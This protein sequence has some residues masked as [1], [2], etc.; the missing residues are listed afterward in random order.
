MDLTYDP[1]GKR[2]NFYCTYEQRDIPKRAGFRHFDKQRRCWWTEHPH[3]A[4]RLFS[5]AKQERTRLH[6]RS[7]A[8]TMSAQKIA[9]NLV[10]LPA[11]IELPTIPVPANRAYRSFQVAGIHYML[12]HPR[13][14]NADDPGLGKTIEAIGVI[15]AD[16][17]LHR[18]LIVCLAGMKIN[19]ARELQRWLTRDY[20]ISIA[21]SKKWRAQIVTPGD[22]GQITIINY[23]ALSK[24]PDKLTGIAWDCFIADE[25]HMLK[26]A[27]TK[28]SQHAY[29]ITASKRTIFLTGTPAPNYPRELF[30]LVH[31]LDPEGFPDF[32][33]YAQEFCG[34]EVRE[35]GSKERGTYKRFVTYNGR[36][37]EDRLQDLLRSRVMLR[38]EK[39]HC[40]DLPPKIRQIITLPPDGFGAYIRDERARWAVNRNQRVQLAVAS[41]LAKAT[42]DDATY[43]KAVQ[44]LR[45]RF[46]YDFRKL[47]HHR[48]QL[49]IAKLPYC[50]AH[51]KN[52]L[53][54]CDKLIVFGYHREVMNRLYKEF[55]PKDAVIV[56]GQQKNMAKRQEAVDR[57][58]QDPSARIFLGQLEAAGTS[59]TLTA[60][61]RVIFLEADWRP[62]IITQAEDRAHRIGQENA[63]GLLIQFLL[64]DGTLEVE[65]AQ[66]VVQK[67]EGAERILNREDPA[68]LVAGLEEP[69]TATLTQADIRD[70][71]NKLEAFRLNSAQYRERLRAIPD[72]KCSDPDRSLRDALV[73][74]AQWRPGHFIL[75]DVLLD[76]YAA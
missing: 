34:P 65:M 15:N 43:R 36:S 66:R 29:S 53:E 62:Y 46:D 22:Y 39:K 2:Y 6:L 21:T 14:L 25:A 51:V 47:A 60:A 48:Q 1:I 63:L 44:R 72:D 5:H 73:L 33:D 16:L 8:R 31:Y 4:M 35:Y 3:V 26:G 55:G 12:Q 76:R 75:A 19:W 13:V 30:P 20:E 23:D 45:S 11:D 37:N 59:W 68:Y 71:V 69:S 67:Q 41:E 7:L 52:A 38:R 17:S 40:L 24:H 58:Q 54:E 64:V 56:T 32:Y 42:L 28:R 57:F 49:G 9:S 74:D 27:E 50:I 18:I 10:E 61:Q 70:R